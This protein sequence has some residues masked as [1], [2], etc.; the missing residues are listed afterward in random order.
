MAR[1]KQV[2][3][4]IG[5]M[6]LDDDY[7]EDFFD[8]PHKAANKLVGSLTNDELAQVLRIAGQRGISV[9][10]VEYIRQVNVAFDNLYALINCPTFPC[11][12]PDPWD[13]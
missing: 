13:A 4:I 1:S 10:K 11:P 3:A 6:V 9:D 7:R 2:Y 5:L 12:D 8:D